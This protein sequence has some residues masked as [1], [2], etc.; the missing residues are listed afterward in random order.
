MRLNYAYYPLYL[1]WYFVLAMIGTIQM[2]IAYSQAPA[3][4]T[5]SRPNIIII[6]ADD[7]GYMDVGFQGCKDIPTP[8]IDRI[9][10]EGVTFTQ[11]YV[12]YP[13][14]GPSRAGLITGRYQDR[15]GFGRNPLFA[16]NDS[17]MGLPTSERT[18]AE[19][20]KPAGYRS[21]AIGKWHLGAHP[22][23]RPL[24]RGFDEFFG[25][26]SGGHSYFP[27][28]W[29]RTDEYDL[30]QQYDAYHTRLLRNHERV[31]EASY[32]TDALSR[33]AVDFIERN[34]DSTFFMYLAYNAPHTP[35]QATE[36]YL[37]RVDSI[38]DPKRQTFAAMVCALDDG[39]G[40]I[41]DA[42]S[43]T[44]IDE[45]TMIFFLSD[46]GG[47]EKANGSDNGILRGG[48]SDL[49]EGG[50]RVPFAL[51]WPQVLPDGLIFDPAVISLDIF[52]TV[53]AQV[54]IHSDS[55]PALD[56]INLIPFLM[57]DQEDIPHDYLF[58]RKFD[59]DEYAARNAAGEKIFKNAQT[60]RYVD[61]P[62][63]PGEDPS[64]FFE[65]PPR[66]RVLNEIWQQWNLQM[67]DPSFPGLRSD[68][69][70]TQKHPDRFLRPASH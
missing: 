59:Q 36:K 67:A 52:A 16:P 41:L 70:Y 44:G 7:L 17:S 64:I 6:L 4:H 2:N 29:S 21:I 33:E 58:W 45:N 53:V 13:V 55:L 56:G 3:S 47:P 28:L 30:E 10:R 62:G 37:R 63:N 50:V 14:C 69:T 22:D 39:V 32:L 34:Q 60:I 54:P 51:R 38:Q 8:N 68:S 43:E 61:L 49:L 65:D 20:L 9:A 31:H 57:S 27:E 15:F 35:L 25:F 66:V 1:K 24:E 42:L 11:G 5:P 19:I 40:D 26:L 46:N 12:S 48:K 18:L 23:L